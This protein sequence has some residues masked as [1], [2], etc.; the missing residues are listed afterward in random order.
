MENGLSKNEIEYLLSLEKNYVE[1]QK[2]KFPSLGGKIA[3]PLISKDKSEDFILDISRSRVDI[4]KNTFQNRVRK[5]IILLRLDINSAPHRNPDGEVLTGPHLH[6][7]TEGY[8]DKYA[9]S[10]PEFFDDC[11]EPKDFL[12]KFMDYCH[13]IKKP[14]IE[15][16]LFI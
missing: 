1:S 4:I 2:F 8:G 10:L 9:Y 15:E 11:K 3:I 16:D 7:Y 5:T 14:I 13:I 12:E 6:I